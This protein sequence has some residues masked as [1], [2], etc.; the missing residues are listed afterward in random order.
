MTTI[1]PLIPGEERS[2]ALDEFTTI[3]LTIPSKASLKVFFTIASQGNRHA[4]FTLEEDARL[5]LYGNFRGRMKEDIS[6]VT[7]AIHKGRG[8]YSRTVVRGIVDDESHMKYEGIIKILPDAH[9]SDAFLEQRALIL[10]EGAH[11][12]MSPL[13]EIEAHDVKASHAAS[14]GKINEDQIY[15]L[16]SRGVTGQEAR[17]MIAEGFLHV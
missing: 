4:R 2:I 12:T 14:V 16:K 5:E 7:E 9:E 1:L 17:T 8:S 6:L 13:L 15:Y 10:G 11:A 3:D